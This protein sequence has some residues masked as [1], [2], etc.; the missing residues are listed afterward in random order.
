MLDADRVRSLPRI[1]PPVLTAYLD[2]NPATPRNQGHP[3]G[4]LAWL[5]TSARALEDQGVAHDPAAFR[6]QVR[7]LERHVQAHPPRARGLVAFCGRHAWESLPL[8][9][10]VEDELHWGP[11]ALKQLFW[12]L[13]EHRPAGVVVVSRTDARF[14][15]IWLGEIVEE[16]RE[17]IALDTSGWR[18]KHLVGP[19][20]AGVARRRGVQRDRFARR[21]E[22]QYGRSAAEIGARVRRWGDRHRLRPVLLAGS[23]ALVDAVFAALPT[24]FRPRVAIRRENL[25]RLAPAALQTRVEPILARWNRDDELARV[26]ALLE[27]AGSRRVAAGLDRTLA[28]LQEGRVRELVIGRGI[29]GTVRQCERCGWVD[30]SADPGCRR[31]GGP[32]RVATLRVVIPELARRHGASVEVVAGRAATRLRRTEGIGAWLDSNREGRRRNVA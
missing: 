12:L 24:R 15:R 31:C 21:L 10:T 1:A 26:D 7:R 4:Y 5:R 8:Q 18:T 22:A 6:E 23:T 11:P 25:S 27:A 3:P 14:F 16:P 28:R 29:D 2:T 30:R 32:R 13:D 9:V 17:A 19:S 20:H